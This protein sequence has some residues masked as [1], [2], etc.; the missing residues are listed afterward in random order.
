[1]ACAVQLRLERSRSRQ[2]H[3]VRYGR[4]GLVRCNYQFVFAKL[5]HG[6]RNAIKTAI[7]LRG[8]NLPAQN[9]SVVATGPDPPFR[10][11]LAPRDYDR[12][13]S[14][15]KTMGCKIYIG[16]AAVAILTYLACQKTLVSVKFSSHIAADVDTVFSFLRNPEN[17]PKVHP[18]MKKLEIQEGPVAVVDSDKER[19]Q[20]LVY[21]HIPMVGSLSFPVN[22]VVDPEETT[23]VFEIEVLN[24]VMHGRGEWIMERKH[25]D[26]S[27]TVF[28]EET[29]YYCPWIFSWFTQQQLTDS[30]YQ[31][32]SNIKRLLEAL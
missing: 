12:P 9:K 2:T 22:W 5:L 30:H 10:V 15:S 16:I 3:T 26:D 4:E 27:I 7:A 14:R 28:I 21:E 31:Q 13:G 8:F 17:L 32:I 18:F 6:V 25:G 24:G 19:S 11:G 23:I 29:H 1:M 20:L